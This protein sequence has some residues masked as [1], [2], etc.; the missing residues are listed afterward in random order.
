MPNETEPNLVAFAPDAPSLSRVQL[1]LGLVF[2]QRS[3]QVSALS[4]LLP[5]SHSLAG[6]APF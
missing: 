4:L 1:S 2:S 6:H 5:F 3:F